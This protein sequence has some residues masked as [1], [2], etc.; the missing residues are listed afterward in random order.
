MKKIIIL[1]KNLSKICVICGFF[2]SS[3]GVAAQISPYY[4]YTFNQG[5]S[6]GKDKEATFGSGITNDLGC[7]VILNEDNTLLGLYE[8]SYQGP[9]LKEDEGDLF[10]DRYQDHLL[11]LSWIRKLREEMTLKGRIDYLKSFTRSGLSENWEDGD[12]NYDRLG[13]GLDLLLPFRGADLDLAWRIADLSYPNYTYL[14]GEIDPSYDQPRYDHLMNKLYF[15]AKYPLHPRITPKASYEYIHK[16]YE[17]EYVKDEKDGETTG[18]KQKDSIHTL[19]FYIPYSTRENLTIGLD[20]EFSFLG[21][22]YNNVKFNA[23]GET[24][25]DITPSF[26]NYNSYEFEPWV[27]FLAKGMDFGASI[28]YKIKNYTDRK[29]EDKD[30]AFFEDERK[31]EDKILFLLLEAIKPI[32]E[33]LSAGLYYGFKNTSSNMKR[34]GYNYQNHSFGIKLTFEH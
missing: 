17:N 8:M 11:L 9:G 29:A 3:S 2:F 28:S 26:Y 32:N 18:T 15:E 23:T 21:S 10:T 7:Q 27:R 1:L 33:N 12:Y 31:Q 16:G 20:G 34:T 14:L 22:N 6:W 13:F 30:G 4:H 19:S 5:Y 24:I 25:T